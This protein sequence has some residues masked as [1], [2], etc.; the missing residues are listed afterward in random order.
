MKAYIGCSGWSYDAWLGHFYPKRLESRRWLE[1]YSKVFDYVE[2]DSSFYRTPNRYTTVRWAT[3]T[4]DDF[5]FTAKFP[6]VVT[7]DTR[8]GGGLDMLLHFFEIMKPLENKMLCLLMQLPPSLKKEE[9]LP[10][11]ERLI[12]HL[13]KKYRYAIEVRHASWFDKEVY[14]LLKTNDICLAWSQLDTIQTP[15]ELTTD[16]FYVRLIGDRSIDEK[17]FGKIQKDREK[18]MDSWKRQIK[19]TGSRTKF[20]IVAANNHYAGFGPGTASE[21]RKMLDLPGVSWEETKQA[22]L[23]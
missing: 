2:I 16:F 9:G 4:P 17:D 12:P 11:L 3:M 20:G 13:W 8:L 10:K 22:R 5:K 18:E 15:P 6:Q 23:D 1:Y 7:H 21:F 19:K 14:D